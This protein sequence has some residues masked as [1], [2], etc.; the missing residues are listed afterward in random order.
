[1][2]QC[3]G[4]LLSDLS[5]FPFVQ[6]IALLLCADFAGKVPIWFNLRFHVGQ[7]C[8]WMKTGLESDLNTLRK[9]FEPKLM[10]VLND[11]PLPVFF[12]LG[13][14][15]FF[16]SDLRYDS[17]IWCFHCST[18][19]Q[20]SWSIETVHC[21]KVRGVMVV[22][23]VVILACNMIFIPA[24]KKNWS[25]STQHVFIL[26]KLHRTPPC[27]SG[28]QWQISMA[29]IPFKLPF[30]IFGRTFGSKFLLNKK[31]KKASRR[32][33]E[34]RRN[35]GDAGPL[36]NWKSK[37]ARSLTKSPGS[38]IVDVFWK[39]S[40]ME[41]HRPRIGNADLQRR[42][43]LVQGVPVDSQVSWFQASCA[44]ADQLTEEQIAEFK[45]AFSLFDKDGDGTITTKELG[46]VMRSLG[47]NPTEAE[48]QDMINEA[49][50]M[51]KSLY[52]FMWGALLPWKWLHSK[53]SEPMIWTGN[54][55]RSD[56]QLQFSIYF[57]LMYYHIIRTGHK[58][59]KAR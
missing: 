28:S 13:I 51:K 9:Q 34:R 30:R 36:V 21:V 22:V 54:H 29:K 19:L 37:D 8:N 47:Q 25:S 16:G 38:N 48:L 43:I 42:P 44:M 15:I 11:S 7:L 55:E 50:L 18:H 57:W 35:R 33:E 56:R 23:P 39:T 20:R 12:V 59:C 14:L 58:H 46:T 53:P 45:E 31:I 17:L 49:G 4:F 27:P 5:V 40:N 6:W 2:F 41:R 1:M 32:R 26:L 3:I 24:V 52:V 10:L